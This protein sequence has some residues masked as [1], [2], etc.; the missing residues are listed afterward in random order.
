M[1]C[2]WRRGLCLFRRPDLLALLPALPLLAW[3]LGGEGWMVAVALGL[4][5]LVAG[6][7]LLA[8]A[9]AE[10]AAGSPDGALPPSGAALA[11]RGW[12]LGAIDAALA[13][14]QRSGSPVWVMVLVL[15]SAD[16]LARDHG[17]V[18]LDVLVN[19]VGHR[20]QWAA[21]AY[22]TVARID[23]ATF[24]IVLT[25][26][27]RK[28]G[29]SW[30]ERLARRLQDDAAVPLVMDGTAIRPSISVGTCA[31]EALAQPDAATMLDAAEIAAGQALR[32]GPGAIV[33]FCPA[34]RATGSHRTPATVIAAALETGAIHAVFQPQVDT[35]TGALAGVE[36]LVRW[37]RDGV[38]ASPG[39]F[40]PDLH[41]LGLSERL[42]Q[43]MLSDA[44]DAL[45]ALEEAGINLPSVGL[46]LAEE[47]LRCPNL[48]DAILWELD[49][50]NLA[51]ARLT[52]EILESV[53]AGDRSDMMMRN[54]DALARAGCGVA[55]DDFGT[56]HASIANIR[57]FAVEH[58][59]VDRSFVTGVD[60]DG[61]Q[62]RLVCA[63]LSMAQQ[64][65]LGVIAEG[66]ETEAEA[67]ML[68]ELGCNVQQGYAIARPMTRDALVSWAQ[69]QA[70]TP[71]LCRSAPPT[72]APTRH[73]AVAR[74][75]DRHT[76]SAL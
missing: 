24:A 36:A 34:M 54:V 8:R 22:G 23:A 72:R 29:A 12:L 52:V 56:G 61:L 35:L 75:K 18:A 76:H 4:P 27:G 21:R 68:R 63:I 67:Q 3:W 33:Q 62:Q 9:G 10:P 19:R 66:V 44:L 58:L 26:G 30:I 65:D 11:L 1:T 53:V 42:T 73:P 43:R 15:D 28:A 5:L 69:T 74:V 31:P 49:C 55:L 50:R 2:A 41:R 70:Q 20:L 6:A 14:R 45:Q 60:R 38:S 32:E 40:L 17:R 51:P 71:G 59:K 16:G 64:L 47:E 46:N 7:G 37:Q 39:E 13:D 48:A 57:S 25:P